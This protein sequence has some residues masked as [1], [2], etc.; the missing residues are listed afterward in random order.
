MLTTTMLVKIYNLLM[1]HLVSFF[2]SCKLQFIFLK[3]ANSGVVALVESKDT[4]SQLC[5]GVSFA[6]EL[7]ANVSF[8]VALSARAVAPPATLPAPMVIIMPNG[9]ALEAEPAA[10]ALS[11]LRPD[12]LGPLVALAHADKG[13]L[14]VHSALLMLNRRL[15]FG[16]HSERSTTCRYCCNWIVGA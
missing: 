5:Q 14:T 11:A 3:P 12:D 16:L 15:H 4:A 8:A 1:Q 6:F 13:S 7:D 10:K 2:V 9:D